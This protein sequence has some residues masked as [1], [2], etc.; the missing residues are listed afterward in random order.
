MYNEYAQEYYQPKL[1]VIQEKANKKGFYNRLVYLFKEREKISHLLHQ[2]GENNQTPIKQNMVNAY[3]LD[4]IHTYITEGKAD[5]DMQEIVNTWADKYEKFIDNRSRSIK[6]YLKEN[7]EVLPVEII[8]AFT[9][10]NTT[11]ISLVS[12]ERLCGIC[13]GMILLKEYI[14]IEIQE[15]LE[16]HTFTAELMNEIRE[17]YGTKILWSDTTSSLAKLLNM[18]FFSSS[19][20][21]KKGG[22]STEKSQIAYAHFE[23]KAQGK[24]KP[25]SF[26]SYKRPIL[27]T[28]IEAKNDHPKLKLLL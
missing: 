23:V 22:T 5:E 6:T 3:A 18:L 11:D 27:E 20:E 16:K 19:I 13:Y 10:E 17:K 7:G 28:Q 15:Q 25:V 9:A 1:S 12:K 14:D 24:D 21:L 2:L 8:E 4:E 26:A